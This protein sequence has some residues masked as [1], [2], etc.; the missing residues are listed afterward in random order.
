M[1]D[2]LRHDRAEPGH[3]IG[4]PLRDASAMQGKIGASG[5]SSHPVVVLT[6]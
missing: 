4:Q 6:L 5:P 1:H 3:P 2:G